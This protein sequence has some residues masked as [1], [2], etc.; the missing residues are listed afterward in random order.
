ML[1]IWTSAIGRCL[2]MA[3]VCSA[4]GGDSNASPHP[5]SAAE[6]DPKT[7]LSRSESFVRPQTSQ[8]LAD[9]ARRL[10]AAGM[11]SQAQQLLREA[12]QVW[13]AEQQTLMRQQ[14]PEESAPVDREGLVTR[15]LQQG[16]YPLA[17][18]VLRDWSRQEPGDPVA[19]VLQAASYYGQGYPELALRE[20]RGMRGDPPPPLQGVIDLFSKLLQMQMNGV[21][22][23]VEANP[24]NVQFVGESGDFEPGGLR[25]SEKPKLPESAV[26][27]MGRL[28]A[29]LPTQG[30]FW[31]LYGEL[32]NATGDP[33]SA[34]EA[35]KLAKGLQYFP[36]PLRDRFRLLESHVQEMDRQLQVQLAKASSTAPAAETAE[37]PTPTGSGVRQ[38]G[39]RT[40]VIVVAVIG[41][42]LLLLLI[43]LQLREW[44]KRARSVTKDEGRRQ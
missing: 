18:E 9:S 3:I 34:F 20:F 33:L 19:A 5:L 7:V 43:I 4:P 13:L 35:F 21:N 38:L 26:Q 40:Q 42:I 36:R 41:V 28:V 25:A 14:T 39:S 8:E 1:P 23:G 22:P 6:L 11:T 29:L 32:L 30:H 31:G 17:D 37:E 15:L 12:Q 16:Q 44:R 24:W 2:A 27:D 10:Q